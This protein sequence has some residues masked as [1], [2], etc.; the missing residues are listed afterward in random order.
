M[1]YVMPAHLRQEA[2][3]ALGLD[4]SSAQVETSMIR[5][6]VLENGHSMALV[7]PE[8]HVDQKTDREKL[9]GFI[10][11]F[12]AASAEAFTHSSSSDDCRDTG[13]QAFVNFCDAHNNCYT[14]N[15]VNLAE[16]IYNEARGERM[17]SRYMVGWTMKDRAFQ[18][19]VPPLLA[20]VCT[21]YPGAMASSAATTNVCLNTN[22]IPAG[23]PTY[24]TESQ[25]VCCAIHGGTTSTGT[26]QVQ[27]DDTHQSFNNLVTSG[28]IYVAHYILDGLVPDPSTGWIPP[29][30][31]SCNFSDATVDG[32]GTGFPGVSAI[33]AMGRPLSGSGIP[34]CYTGANFF[35]PSPGGPQEYRGRPTPATPYSGSVNCVWDSGVV[36]PGGP[37]ATRDNYYRNRQGVA[38]LLTVQS[39]LTIKKRTLFSDESQGTQQSTTGSA[40]LL[41][42][43]KWPQ[44]NTAGVVALNSSNAVMYRAFN[45]RA[46]GSGTSASWSSWQSMGLSALDV[47]AMAF[48]NGQADI[49]AA[50]TDSCT[51][52]RNH[53]DTTTKT[54]G[55][56][57]AWASCGDRV[58]AAAMPDGKALFA[59]RAS[60]NGNQAAYLYFNGTSWSSSFTTLPGITVSDL[61][62]T[63]SATPIGG[64]RATLWAVGSDNCT[65]YYSNWNGASWTA[66]NTWTS[67]YRAVSSF[68]TSDGDSYLALIG[69]DNRFSLER[70]DGSAW[71]PIVAQGTSQWIAGTGVDA[72]R[73]ND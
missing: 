41:T 11:M 19:L 35:D 43:L 71:L 26:S 46:T 62:F 40:R 61:A 32:C 8:T 20:P 47:V 1:I 63:S 59:L 67:C 4:A 70:F 5:T 16:V 69:S 52:Q 51:I 50:G 73:P 45:G 29:G 65:V 66:W 36:C 33:D 42:T 2:L 9:G 37:D 56:F 49:F 13:W 24:V 12:L 64:I 27:F 55:G 21:T 6:R 3:E 68:N 15:A 23:D 10:E 60:Q 48:P 14:P 39:D 22:N 72:F 18:R 54:W 44:D 28:A 17:G 53:F 30:V 31:S 34:F 58:A 7:L 25:R 38:T 57:S